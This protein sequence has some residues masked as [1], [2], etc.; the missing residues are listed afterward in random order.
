MHQL[1]HQLPALEGPERVLICSCAQ[2]FPA[3]GACP[4]CCTILGLGPPDV[5]VHLRHRVLKSQGGCKQCPAEQPG[6]ALPT[7]RVSRKRGG[8]G[9][10]SLSRVIGQYLDLLEARPLSKAAQGATSA[11][12]KA[13]AGSGDL[14]SSAMTKG[15]PAGP[16]GKQE[17]T[18]RRWMGW[19]TA[20]L[21]FA[22]TSNST[23]RLTTSVKCSPLMC[24]HRTEPMLQFDKSG[25]DRRA[26]V[27]QIV[28]WELERSPQPDWGLRVLD[29]SARIL[30]GRYPGLHL[31]E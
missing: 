6:H 3:V 4:A 1:P 5:M 20:A 11:W 23:S 13:R 31:L 27:S 9:G 30:V 26:G 14:Q 22:I 29:S 19:A 17:G 24:L 16:S 2:N 15:G 12:Q 8:E 28:G 21:S 25:M 10:W 7:C 18:R